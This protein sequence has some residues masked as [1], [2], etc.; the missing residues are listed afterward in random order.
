MRLSLI[1]WSTVYLSNDVKNIINIMYE[2]LDSGTV[3]Y[4]FII[5]KASKMLMTFSVKI[6]GTWWCKSQTC[7]VFET[8]SS[9]LW[10]RSFL[11]F[12]KCYN[13]I[14]YNDQKPINTYREVHEQ[15]FII[16]KYTWHCALQLIHCALQPPKCI[17]INFS[18]KLKY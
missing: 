4:L 14:F 10:L 11:F 12:C 16:I 9:K 15:F 6:V 18:Q 7:K 8:Q 17:E 3:M 5:K 13:Y 1:I 2:K